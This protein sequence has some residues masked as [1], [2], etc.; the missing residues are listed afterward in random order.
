MPRNTIPD[1]VKAELERMVAEKHPCS[2]IRM[3]NNLLCNND[4]F[5]NVVREAHKRMNADQ[6][7]GL[8]DAAAR[9]MVWSSTIHLTDTNMFSEAF[10]VNAVLVAKRVGADIV[11]VDDTACVNAFMLPV[12]AM[13]VRDKMNNTRAWMGRSS[14]Q[15][16]RVIRAVLHVR[17]KVLLHENVHV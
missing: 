8:R 6:A 15:N 3:R 11:Y 10:F 9:S 16:G 2:A 7:R 4:V 14:R 12:V 17:R 5:Q 1:S 13:F